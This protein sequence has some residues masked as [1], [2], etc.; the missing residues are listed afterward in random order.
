MGDE[1]PTEGIVRVGENVTIGY[2][3]QIQ[4]HLEFEENLF[5]YFVK[6]TGCYFGEAYGQLARFMFDKDAVKKKIWQLSPGERSRF[7]LAIFANKNYDFLILDEPDNHL[8]IET[9]EVLEQSL[10]KFKG[11]LLLV[12]HDRYFVESVGVEKMLNLKDGILSYI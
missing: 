4:T 9:K 10:S 7:K 12:S 3:S 6:E 5:D 11:T 2:F 8:D 1:K